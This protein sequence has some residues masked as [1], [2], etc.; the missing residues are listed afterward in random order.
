MTWDVS[1]ATAYVYATHGAELQQMLDA[2]VEHARRLDADG[3]L[4]EATADRIVAAYVAA[5]TALVDR[6]IEALLRPALEDAIADR[7]VLAEAV[8]RGERHGR[9]REEIAGDLIDSVI[10]GVLATQK[11]RL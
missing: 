10:H 5:Q 9:S 2:F 4:D 11:A 8:Q 3:R 1:A 6:A 7:M